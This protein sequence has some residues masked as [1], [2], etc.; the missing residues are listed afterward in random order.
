MAPFEWLG[1]IHCIVYEYFTYIIFF[2]YP[3]SFSGLSL[4]EGLVVMG[5]THVPC[6]VWAGLA[7]TENL[8]ISMG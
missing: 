5:L 6:I 3:F 8:L 4:S 2:K 7:D 1:N